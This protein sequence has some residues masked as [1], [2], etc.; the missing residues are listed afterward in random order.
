MKKILQ[1]AGAAKNIS[2]CF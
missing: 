2:V 1:R